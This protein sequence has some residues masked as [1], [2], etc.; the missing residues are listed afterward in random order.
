MQTSIKVD[1][2]LMDTALELSGFKSKKA[3]V[4]EALKIFVQMLQQR[5]IQEL[6]GKLKWEGDLEQMRTD[7]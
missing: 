4:E 7:K 3:V 5:S 1:D 6:R 2:Q